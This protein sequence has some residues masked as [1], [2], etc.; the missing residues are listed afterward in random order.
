V[1]YEIVSC[2]V[3]AEEE[4]NHRQGNDRHRFEPCPCLWRYEIEAGLSDH[5]PKQEEYRNA[6]QTGHPADMLGR[7]TTHEQSAKRNEQNRLV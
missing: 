4:R 2:E 6:R 3:S 1:A 7:Q 5:D